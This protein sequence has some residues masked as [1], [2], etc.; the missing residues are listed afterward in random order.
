MVSCT[1]RTIYK[2][3]DDLIS[4][5]QMINLWT[6]IYIAYGTRGIK[7]KKLEQKISYLPLV[8]NKYKIDSV[9]FMRSN[10]YYT[11]KVELYE[12]MF[13]SVEKN[14]KR[15]R[16]SYDPNMVDVD[17]KLPAHIRDSIREARKFM[18]N[19]ELPKVLLEKKATPKKAIKK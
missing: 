15:L 19:D 18:K 4:K 13:K 14:L 8:Y 9:R 2:K 16:D 7:N 6:D 5:N 10:I 3:P 1:S 12:E 17:P 11:S